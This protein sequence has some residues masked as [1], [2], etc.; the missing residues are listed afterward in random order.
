MVELLKM[1][2]EQ[3]ISCTNNFMRLYLIDIFL[4]KLYL[5]KFTKMINNVND[6]FIDLKKD[7][8]NL[9]DIIDLGSNEKVYSLDMI[10]VNIC[11]AEKFIKG[12]LSA[13]ENILLQSNNGKR[14]YYTFSYPNLGWTQYDHNSIQSVYKLSQIKTRYELYKIYKNEKVNL[15]LRLHSIA[16][17]IIKNGDYFRNLYEGVEKARKFTKDNRLVYITFSNPFHGIINTNMNTKKYTGKELLLLYNIG[18]SKKF[19][20]LGI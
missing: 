8:T 12:L 17:F 3:I 20:S 6:T 18:I 5:F 11:S 16:A 10:V 13:R 15:R 14:G 1:H 19:T 4:V 9:D 7:E 2:L